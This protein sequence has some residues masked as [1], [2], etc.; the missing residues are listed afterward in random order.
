MTTPQ[1]MNVI[2]YPQDED[3]FKIRGD[4]LEKLHLLGGEKQFGD[5]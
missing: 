1:I 4:V 3:D 5:S 2:R